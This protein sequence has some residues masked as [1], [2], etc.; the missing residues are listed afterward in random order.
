[1]SEL[2]D[3]QA[4]LIRAAKDG[5][6]Q[7]GRNGYIVGGRPADPATTRLITDLI[8]AQRLYLPPTSGDLSW[9]PVMPTP[10]G[11]QEA[12]R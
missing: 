8:A 2:T 11:W 5:K 3:A 4:A 10:S 1:M 12:R 7:L 6:V 9:R